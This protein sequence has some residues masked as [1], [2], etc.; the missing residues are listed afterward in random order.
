[1]QIKFG[2]SINIVYRRIYFK[3]VYTIDHKQWKCIYWDCNDYIFNSLKYSLH[4]SQSLI[5]TI[6]LII[7][8]C[9][10]KLYCYNKKWLCSRDM[11][12]TRTL[13]THL[14]VSVYT[15]TH[16][17]TCTSTC[18]LTHIHIPHSRTPALMHSHAHA[19][20]HVHTQDLVSIL[21]RFCSWDFQK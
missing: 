2:P 18:T 14:S 1:M 20:M 8:F 6:I 3:M 12:K 10:L 7:L 4:E 21:T 19:C 5:P 9:S 16:T 17:Q 13:H 11:V 15:N